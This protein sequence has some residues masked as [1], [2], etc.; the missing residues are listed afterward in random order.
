MAT[1][2]RA[3]RAQAHDEIGQTLQRDAGVIVERWARRA[4]EEQ[5]NAP[6]VHHDVLRD[7]LSELLNA[8]GQSLSET[9]DPDTGTHCK[10]AH[11]H[12]LQRWVNGWSLLD[13][14]R[15]YQILRLVILDYLQETLERPLRVSEAMAVGLFLDEAIA[16]SVVAFVRSCEELDQ[17]VQNE[18]R[19]RELALRDA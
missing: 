2:P 10:P 12:G 17:K 1:D 15:D 9:D 6:R 5:P 19:Q 3:V 14:V 11:T 8:L 4:L 7:H 18:L 13:V 16:V